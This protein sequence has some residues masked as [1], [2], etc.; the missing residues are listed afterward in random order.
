MIMEKTPQPFAYSLTVKELKQRSNS[1]EIR[2][3]LNPA[4][5]KRFW[6]SGEMSGPCSSKYD[7]KEPA[8]FAVS[9]EGIAIL[10]NVGDARVEHVIT[11]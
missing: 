3:L 1:D 2:V 9:H 4:T 5:K 8:Q 10:C 6:N 11:L 7:A